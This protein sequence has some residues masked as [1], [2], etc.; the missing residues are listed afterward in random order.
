MNIIIDHP[1]VD[2]AGS[3]WELAKNTSLDL[4]SSYSYLMMAEFFSDTCMIARD[5]DKLIAF[6]TG[7]QFKSSPD[8]YFV[9]QIAVDPDYRNQKL[10]QKMIYQMVKEVDPQFIQANI[11]TANK[12]SI[13]MFKIVAENYNTEFKSSRG[14][15]EEDFPDDHQAEMLITIGPL[16]RF[17]YD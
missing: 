13:N 10:A 14:F 15:S 7:F 5:E 11:T 9:W 3:M 1:S 4:N 6:M 12:A 2:D 16:R 17:R 8:S